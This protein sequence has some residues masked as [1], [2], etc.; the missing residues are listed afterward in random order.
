MGNNIY[1]T[2][3][4]RGLKPKM[5]IMREDRNALIED[6]FH[7]NYMYNRPSDQLR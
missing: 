4:R 5:R 7:T 6:F 1:F 2:V 3:G